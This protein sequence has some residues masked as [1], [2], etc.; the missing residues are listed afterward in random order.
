GRMRWIL[1]Q[2]P[3]AVEAEK[4]QPATRRHA[5]G[6]PEKGV[7]FWQRATVQVDSAYFQAALILPSSSPAAALASGKLGLS[8]PPP[9]QAAHLR[10]GTACWLRVMLLP[11]APHG[12]PLT[13]HVTVT[14]PDKERLRLPILAERE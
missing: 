9:L 5:A 6:K 7:S 1:L 12:R 14:L 2:C 4:A 13:G 11:S 10:P 8:I 3:D